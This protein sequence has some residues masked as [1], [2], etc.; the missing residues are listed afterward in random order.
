MA[1]D[2]PVK[3]YDNATQAGDPAREAVVVSPSDSTDLTFYPT[4]L[5][6]GTS[7]N[8][9]VVMA[10]AHIPGMTSTAAGAAAVLFSNLP[11]GWHPIR[12]GRI[13]ALNST[14]SSVIAVRR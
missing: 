3:E 10:A 12:V 9:N 8:L 6:V 13:M 1:I 7:G 4:A 14:A 2:S 11:V 5:Y